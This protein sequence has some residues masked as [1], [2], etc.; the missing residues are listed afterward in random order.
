MVYMSTTK[1]HD[2]ITNLTEVLNLI[3]DGASTHPKMMVQIREALDAGY[4]LITAD[5]LKAGD[6]VMYCTTDP[7]GWGP[8]GGLQSSVVT[9]V[10]ATKVWGMDMLHV[11]H[12]GE[13][14]EV[15]PYEY[16][17]ALPRN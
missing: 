16:A 11:H 8:F 1:G 6:R 7:L 9:E 5:T 17:L 3:A 4:G 12:D 13:V 15:A 10:V 14:T 2:M